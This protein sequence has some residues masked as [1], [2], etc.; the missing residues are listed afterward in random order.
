[1]MLTNEIKENIDVETEMRGKR[2]RRLNRVIKEQFAFDRPVRAFFVICISA[3]SLAGW[4]LQDEI[5]A[6]HGQ[7]SVGYWDFLLTG[8]LRLEGLASNWQAAVLQLGSLIVLSSFLYRR[9]APRIP[10]IGAR[11]QQGARDQACYV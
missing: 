8:P 1:M 3:Q 4:R 2:T 11:R 9:R 6:A 5:L 7:S 10:A